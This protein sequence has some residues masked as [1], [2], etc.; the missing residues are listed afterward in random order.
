[1][2]YH[3]ISDSSEFEPEAHVGSNLLSLEALLKKQIL[4][5]PD[6]H[7]PLKLIKRNGEECL[8]DGKAFYPLVGESPLLY[9]SELFDLVINDDKTCDLSQSL[10][11]LKQYYILSK[12]KQ[13]GEINAPLS[14]AP[15]RKIHHRFYSLCKNINGI[16]LDIGCDQPEYSRKFFPSQCEYVGLDPF[17]SDNLFRLI[18][19]GEILPIKSSSIDAIAFN[20]SLDHILD[21]QTAI[22]ESHR[23]LKKGGHL[24]ISSY[25]WLYNSTLLTDSVHFHHFREDEIL[26]SLTNKFDIISLVRYECPKLAGIENNNESSNELF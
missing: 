6:Q 4:V 14:S 10:S 8:S 20:T 5:S 24:L 17:A 9:P 13:R 21:Y 22:N 1:M 12:I 23:S 26:H 25:A 2:K 19:I 18:G 16:V 3:L 7:T 11:P 15:A